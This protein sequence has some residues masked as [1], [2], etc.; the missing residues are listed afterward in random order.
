[1]ATPVERPGFSFYQKEKKG[2]SMLP[3]LFSIGPFTVYSYGL[4]TA[5]G[6]MA[7]IWIGEHLIQKKRLAEDGF[8]FGMGIACVIGGYASSKLLF[9]IT[10]LPEIIENPARLLDFSSGFVVYGGLIGGVLTGCLYCRIKKVDF[11][12]VFDLAVPLVALAQ[13][14]GRI[15]CFLA[16]C[17]YGR[18]TDGPFGVVFHDSVYAPGGMRLFPVQLLS[19]ALN[20]CNCLF[21]YF[22]WKK[23]GLKKGCVGA[24]YIMTYSIGRFGLEYLR[25][26]L[27]RGSVGMFSTS[28]FISI[29]TLIIG[30]ALFLWRGRASLG[31]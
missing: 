29:F 25:G 22:L 31:E 13:C 1:M 16:G 6:I 18:E 20:L 2:Y 24:I 17:C 7:A 21:L 10:I 5:L 9:W 12:K 28:Q 4:M 23:A 3:E 8:L 11:W 30:L 27:E 19:S 14:I 15:G 26:D